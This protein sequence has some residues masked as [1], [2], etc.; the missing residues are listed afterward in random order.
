MPDKFETGTPNTP[1][2]AGLK[3]SVSFILKEGTE[4]IQE[5]GEK[6]TGQLLNGLLKIKNVT[7]YGPKDAK[8]Q[9]PVVS[10]N[11]NGMGPA[12]IGRKMEKEFG[13]IVRTGLHCAPFTHKKIGTFP[14]GTVRISMGYYNTEKDIEATIEA[15]T[16]LA[17]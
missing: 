6:L 7:V 10:F 17:R 1:G 11:I 9:A 4:K 3:A 12:E 8:K 5:H 14:K 15:V 13:I 2:I 16:S